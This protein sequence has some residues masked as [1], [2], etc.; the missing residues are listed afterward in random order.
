M[1][2]AV[3]SYGHAV[4]KTSDT[5]YIYDRGIGE[6]GTVVRNDNRIGT[7]E[8]NGAREIERESNRTQASEA[9]G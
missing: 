7:G 1:G 4:Y 9:I 3:E 8:G 6:G 2:K 5:R